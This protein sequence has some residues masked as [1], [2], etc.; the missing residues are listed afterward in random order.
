VLLGPEAQ[1]GAFVRLE[2]AADYRFLHFA[3]HG[4]VDESYPDRS[5]LALSVPVDETED[6][7]LRAREIHRMQLQADLVVLSACE[8]ALG[9]VVRG[10]GVLGLARAFLFAGAESVV[11]SLWE[12]ADISTADFMTHLY[13]S[14]VR[15]SKTPA[16]AI[17]EARAALRNSRDF[18]HPY[19]WGAFVLLGPAGS[20]G[21][22]N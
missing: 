11:A 15:E 9:R 17:L 5:S 2:S 20:D 3:T 14:M 22:G 1:E 13:R 16:E 12:V 8:T 7:H 19:F 21:Q 4:L 10:E 6:G 18:A